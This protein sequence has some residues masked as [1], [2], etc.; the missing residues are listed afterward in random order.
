M[1]ELERAMLTVS[2]LHHRL[3]DGSFYGAGS[4]GTATALS[5]NRF[6]DVARTGIG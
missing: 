3:P 5:A 1:D 2:Q 4:P 6:V